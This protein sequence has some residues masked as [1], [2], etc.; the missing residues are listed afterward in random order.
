MLSPLRIF[1]CCHLYQDFARRCFRFIFRNWQLFFSI[2][3][4]V[5]AQKRYF[6]CCNFISPRNALYLSRAPSMQSLCVVL[7][8]TEWP[9]VITRG[10]H[11]TFCILIYF[12]TAMFS[13]EFIKQLGITAWELECV[14]VSRKPWSWYYNEFSQWLRSFRGSM[15]LRANSSSFC[16]SILTHYIFINICPCRHTTGLL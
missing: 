4:G 9:Q 5:L 1:I 2:L 15:S 14:Q 11:S 16:Y 7:R 6:R 3:K 12:T 13:I 10:S 8:S